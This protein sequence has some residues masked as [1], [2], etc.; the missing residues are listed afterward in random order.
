MIDMQQRQEH[1]EQLMD[2][3]L[4]EAKKRGASAAEAGV[5]AI[6]QPG[7]S[8]RDEDSIR[9]LTPTTWPWCLP[10]SDTSGIRL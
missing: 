2:D 5:S 1:L 3:L 10:V 9:R 8:I 6:I 7:G 4:R